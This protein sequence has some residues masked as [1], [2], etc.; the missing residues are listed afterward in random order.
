[1]KRVAKKLL[2]RRRKKEKN[3]QKRKKLKK[4]KRKEGREEEREKRIVKEECVIDVVNYTQLELVFVTEFAV[5]EEDRGR[6]CIITNLAE[7]AKG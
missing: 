6:P 5:R 7:T 2:K 3:T 4:L 1:M